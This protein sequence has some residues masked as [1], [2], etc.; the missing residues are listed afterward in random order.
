MTQV[1]NRG[2]DTCGIRDTMPLNSFEND[3]KDY[4]RFEDRLKTFRQWPVGLPIKPDKLAEAG[5]VY[6]GHNDAVICYSCKGGLHSWDSND[7]PWKE[8]ALWYPDCPFLLK[9]KGEAFVSRVRQQKYEQ[10]GESSGYY[11]SSPADESRSGSMASSTSTS[12]SRS[13]SDSLMECI[14]CCDQERSVVFIPCGHLI[15]CGR[16]CAQLN[17]CPTCRSCIENVVIA[18]TH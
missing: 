15:V 7:D 10:D 18:K 4:H 17:S 6:T 3:V 14:I 2:Y 9:K 8:H 11:S 5:L 1:E 12:R 16:C 13:N